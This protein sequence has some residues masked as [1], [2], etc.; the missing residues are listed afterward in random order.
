MPSLQVRLERESL[1]LSLNQMATLFER[2]KSVIS[3]HLSKVFGDEELAR[4]SVVA[5]YATTAADGKTYQVEHYNLDA[6][7]SVG[8]R[9]NSKRGTQF[10]I[11]ATGVL[12]EHLTKGLTI[13]RQRL[14]TNAREVEAAL[15]LVRRTIASPELSSDMS[16]GLVEVISRYTRTFVLLQRYDEGLLT[17]PG[18]EPGGDLPSV[19]EART[20][21][22]HLRQDLVAQAEA[23]DLFGQERG[24]A[25]AA[26]FG[27]LR[28]TV[29][30]EPAYATLESRAAHLLYFVI[31]DHPF[32]DANKRIASLLFVHFLHRNRRLLVPSGGPVINDIGLAA[33]ALLIAESKP[34]DKDILIRLIMNMLARSE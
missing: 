14:E 12:R 23:G 20:A 3:R 15:E 5:Q 25:L 30:G 34:R 8:Y 17:E 19:D 13:N 26:I 33:L 31:K 4:S 10:R 2:D 27:N 28:Q 18:G 16:R 7:L 6:I 21:V 32:S 11:W 24:Q 1:W 22:A 29:M 9:V